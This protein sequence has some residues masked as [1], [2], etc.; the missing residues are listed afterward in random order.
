MQRF[1]QEPSQ[2]LQQLGRKPSWPK[3]PTHPK[4]KMVGREL[5]RHPYYLYA[6]VPLG[7]QVR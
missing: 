1:V 5:A 6:L 7:S 3:E 2:H 4:R